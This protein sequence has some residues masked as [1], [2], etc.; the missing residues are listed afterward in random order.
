MENILKFLH[1]PAWWFSAF[2]IA[3]VASIIAAFAKDFINRSIAKVS[4]RYRVRKTRKDEER[5]ER[6]QLTASDP[7]LVIM[8][9]TDTVMGFIQV[10]FIGLAASLIGLYR[11]L[12][13]TSSL[14]P[15][16]FFTH[17]LGL[18]ITM[19]YAYRTVIKLQDHLEITE[20]YKAK[21]Q[22]AE[23][24]EPSHSTD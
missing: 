7:A 2:F 13:P 23:N 6:I 19:Y 21:L 18:I 4:N 24:N 16:A 17:T 3:I 9:H 1:D 8:A 5:R 12:R 14:G 15:I 20:A 10:G 22:K 11:L